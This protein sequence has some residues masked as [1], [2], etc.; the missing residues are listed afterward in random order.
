VVASGSSPYGYNAGT[1][2]LTIP[3]D[4]SLS[5][6]PVWGEEPGNDTSF[7][8]AYKVGGVLDNFV[9]RTFSRGTNDQKNASFQENGVGIEAIYEDAVPA[10]P[11]VLLNS[12]G[13]AD[14]KY[15]NYKDYVNFRPSYGLFS[16]TWRQ[17]QS[18]WHAVRNTRNVL[19]VQ[20]SRNGP[21]Q[22]STLSAAYGYL[23][24]LPASASPSDPNNLAQPSA[25]NRWTIIVFGRVS[26]TAS[27]SPLGFVN[28]LFMPGS[29]LRLSS[30]GRD[31]IVFQGSSLNSYF[32]TVIWTSFESFVNKSTSTRHY[33]ITRAG[34]STAG[35]SNAVYIDLASGLVF[36]SINIYHE[37][38][39]GSSVNSVV[40]CV[41][42]VGGTYQFDGLTLNNCVLCANSSSSTVTG[43]EM[44][45]L[46]IDTSCT[47]IT[48]D[49]C[50]LMHDI[51]SSGKGWALRVSA[52]NPLRMYI[53][54]CTFL[55][56]RSQGY[57][58]IYY[59]S[60]SST[61]MLRMTNS[62]VE[63]YGDSNS[64]AAYAARIQANCQCASTVFS[65]ETWA[66]VPGGVTAGGATCGRALFVN[67]PNGLSSRFDDC[68]FIS[69][70]N[71]AVALW[72][73]NQGTYAES[74]YMFNRCTFVSPLSSIFVQ[75]GAGSSV[76]RIYSCH[77]EG[78]ITGSTF[79]FECIHSAS[80]TLFQ[81]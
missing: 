10:T 49:D 13:V 26:E 76:K 16:E 36:S 80:I 1:E 72:M 68:V 63:G 11:S 64:Y 77:F 52:L 3:D 73:S 65:V 12:L 14:R 38:Y 66:T 30:T 15:K 41:G 58:A 34:T 56:P 51:S 29:N 78:A 24:G 69:K 28:V 33:H 71:Q 74:K 47:S 23:S 17:S 55:G 20:G 79:G 67:N 53:N 31:G 57:E 4:S 21:M 61:A 75:T 18:A 54:E 81:V 35:S 6:F 62:V 25:T 8:T 2:T 19:Y 40:R 60:S 27:I 43:A 5:G 22:F 37:A 50:L 42:T 7:F 59:D 45:A 44:S 32:E 9:T 48:I 70:H 46:S 39:S